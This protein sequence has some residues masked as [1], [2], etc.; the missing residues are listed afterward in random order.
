MAELVTAVRE[1]GIGGLVVLGGDG[2]LRAA[3][4]LAADA[5]IPVAGIPATIDN[6]VA[7]SDLS[8]GFDTALAYGVDAAD[9]VR[10]SMESLPRFFAIETLGGPTGH[11]ALALGK[12]VAADAVLVP[13]APTPFAVLAETIARA[14]AGGSALVVASEGV[15]DLEPTLSRAAEAAGTRLRLVRLGHAQ[16]GGAPSPRDR[17]AAIASAAFALDAIAEGRSGIAALRA[18]SLRLAPFTS[19]V[20]AA[21]PDPVAWRGLL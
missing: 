6:D 20:A 15:S 1:L 7:A 10:D 3:G 19:A 12:I 13:E 16:R 11:I 18:G 14:M 21:P 9:R 8:I 4:A 2:S 5:E 17:A